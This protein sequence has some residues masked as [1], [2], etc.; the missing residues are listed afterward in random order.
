ME[1]EVIK[2]KREICPW[3]HQEIDTE[4][5][6]CGEYIASHNSWF[7]GHEAVPMGCVCG[8]EFLEKLEKD[9]KGNQ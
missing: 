8:Y 1:I 2:N 5:C 6:W 9:K 3:C 4:V 7:T